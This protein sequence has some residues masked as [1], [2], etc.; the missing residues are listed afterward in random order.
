MNEMA[1]TNKLLKKAVKGTYKILTSMPKQYSKKVPN[2]LKTSKKIEKTVKFFEN[3]TKD[4]KDT[5]KTL[6]GKNV[7]NSSKKTPHLILIQY[8][9]YK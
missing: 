7:K 1:K 2:N 9:K 4:N 6:K 5:N 3:L 8:M